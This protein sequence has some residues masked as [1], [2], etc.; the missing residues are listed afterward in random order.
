V[1][2]V[3]CRLPGGLLDDDGVLHS[4][5]EV[6][7][8]SGREEELLAG[9]GGD[10]TAVT[11]SEV[12]ARCVTRLGSLPEVDAD[13][14]RRLLVADRQFLLLKLREATFGDLVRGSA[15]CPWPDCGN[16]VAI[17]FSIHDVPVTPAREHGPTFTT[18][19]SPDAVPGVEDAGRTVEFRL[20]TGADQEALSPLLVPGAD[21]AGGTL[22]AALLDACLVGVGGR[23]AQPT[24]IDLS[25]LARREIED[26]MQDVAPHLDLVMAATCVEC[27]RAFE[28]PFDVQGFFFGEL[29]VT[30]DMLRREVHY[31]AFHYHWSEREILELGRER[32]QGYIDVLQDEIERLN[33]R[34]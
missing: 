31:L 32:R 5:A 17:S 6:R 10:R 33:D 20:P 34:A 7:S 18:T 16:R 9:A 15:P 23:P 30:A 14:V 4:D 29:Q 3:L 24:D 19:L 21:D 22:T 28:A 13:V 1:N 11:V 8:L 12:L 27:G 2:P 26:A 25:P